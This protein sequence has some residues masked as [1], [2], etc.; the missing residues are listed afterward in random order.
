RVVVDLEGHGR[1]D[2]IDGVDVSRTVGWFTT[3]FPVA[4]S[5]PAPIGQG[6]RATDW[7]AV[8]KSVKEQLRAVPRRGIGYG[9]L[10]HLV[11]AARLDATRRLGDPD[12]VRQ[13][14]VSFNYLGRADYPGRTDGLIRGMHGEL[15]LAA[16]PQ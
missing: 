8:L 9:A 3:L 1:E 16:D 12:P 7:G 13:P 4:L 10:R 14:H 15:E 6:R 11:E 2:L 5:L